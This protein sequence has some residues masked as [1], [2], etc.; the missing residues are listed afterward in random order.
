M[1]RD[2]FGSVK[3][4]LVLQKAGWHSGHQERA[5]VRL[6]LCHVTT[7]RSCSASAFLEDGVMGTNQ[8]F[9]AL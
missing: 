9:L 7:T 6:K 2:A 5:V 3:V 1:R 8:D 4:L